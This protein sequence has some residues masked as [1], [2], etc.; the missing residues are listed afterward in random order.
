MT[1][2]YL[3][4][5]GLATRNPAG[6]GKEIL[7]A[8]IL[9]ESIQSVEKIAIFLSTVTDSINY[10][11]ELKRCV[12]TAG[13]ITRLTGKK[14]RLDSRMN[15]Y[16]RESFSVFKLKL[17]L[18]LD[19]ITSQNPQNIII[20][21][22]GAVIAGLKHLLMHAIFSESDLLDYPQCGQLLIL[23]DKRIEIKDFN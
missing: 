23:Q 5:H 20:C 12:Q 14:F 9:P 3:F 16:H 2:W 17:H 1:S 8:T 19:E 7:T 10:C 6:Y 11:S 21:T 15:E 22:H 13:I 18:F 4:R